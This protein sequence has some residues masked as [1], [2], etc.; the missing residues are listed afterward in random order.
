MMFG[1]K[2]M[3]FVGTALVVVLL[4]VRTGIHPEGFILK[5]KP[6]PYEFQFLNNGFFN[7]P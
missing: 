5:D 3:I 6:C 1:Q 7:T 2:E 4:G